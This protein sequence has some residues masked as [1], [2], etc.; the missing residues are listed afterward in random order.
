MVYNQLRGSPEY[1]GAPRVI[2][3]AGES[4][5]SHLLPRVERDG[6]ECEVPME[7]LA[8]GEQLAWLRDALDRGDPEPARKVRSERRSVAPRESPTPAAGTSA[9]KADDFRRALLALKQNF[10]ERTGSF[11]GQRW[12]ASSTCWWVPGRR[13]SPYACLLQRDAPGDAPRRR[14]R[15]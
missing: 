9:P 14:D 5:R 1:E 10:Q 2:W 12:R 11:A 13:Y 8:Q 4:D 6:K 15:G 3:L 7:G